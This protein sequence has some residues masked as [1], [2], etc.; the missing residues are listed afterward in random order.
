MTTTQKAPKLRF[1]VRQQRSGYNGY[2]TYYVYDLKRQG[3]VTVH[4][5]SVPEAAKADARN[6]NISEM[7]APHAEDPRPYDVRLAEATAKYDSIYGS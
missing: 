2:C 3:R 7:V 5:H 4:A 1:T 6:L